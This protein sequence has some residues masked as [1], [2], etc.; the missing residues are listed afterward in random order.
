M[1][2]AGYNI[3]ARTLN[4]KDFGVLQQRKRVILIGWKEK[5]DYEYPEF[6][7]MN[8]N[9]TVRDLLEDVPSLQPGTEK[10]FFIQKNR[11][12]I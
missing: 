4:S 2:D 1:R 6:K 12:T 5:L 10:N 7:T 3:T 8:H 9:F 11:A